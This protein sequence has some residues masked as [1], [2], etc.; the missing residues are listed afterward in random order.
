MKASWLL[1]ITFGMVLGCGMQSCSPSRAPVKLPAID[2]SPTSF[3]KEHVNLSEIGS[4]IEYVFLE[5]TKESII[6][7]LGK[8][9]FSEN[10]ILAYDDQI[11]NLKLFSRNGKFIRTI[12]RC[13]KGPGEF[14]GI[15]DCTINEQENRIIVS[16]GFQKKIIIYHLDGTL[17]S[18]FPVTINA[19]YLFDFGSSLLLGTK[20]PL[21]HFNDQFNLHFTDFKG[22]SLLRGLPRPIKEMK[23]H[24]EIAYNNR[25]RY[26]DTLCLWEGCFDT[27]YGITKDL[28]ITPRWRIINS[29][30]YIGYDGYMSGQS[31]RLWELGKYYIGKIFETTDYFFI[32]YGK[33]HQ[34][35]TLLLSKKDQK[36]RNVKLRNES[37]NHSWGF[38]NDIDG[39]YPFWPNGIIDQ[40]TLYSILSVS[41]L[42]E[43]YRSQKNSAT[44]N[45]FNNNTLREKV[46]TMDDLGNPIIMIVTEAFTSHY[47]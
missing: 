7:S 19:H 27:I 10:F 9:R 23:G 13:G 35:Y 6:G 26:Y 15:E 17:V 46:G 36:I 30:E 12:G 5:T 32:E 42:K 3:A 16:A 4:S 39:G 29:G 40:N 41:T 25:Y 38:E 22:N 24:G 47:D 33:N 2:L 18:E 28:Q 11:I 8:L 37:I 44:S 14:I 45:P 43:Y 20:F 31:D 1:L 34:V 21:Q